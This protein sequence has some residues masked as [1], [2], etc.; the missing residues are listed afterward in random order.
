M[1]NQAN[2]QDFRDFIERCENNIQNLTTKQEGHEEHI[3]KLRDQFYEVT[4]KLEQET[5]LREITRTQQG[6]ALFHQMI[7]FEKNEIRK[8]FDENT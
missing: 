7:N 3:K 1:S 5:I 2:S 8:K 6:I 4:T